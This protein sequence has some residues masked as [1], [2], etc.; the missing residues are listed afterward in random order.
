MTTTYAHFIASDRGNIISSENIV[1]NSTFLSTEVDNS[2]FKDTHCEFVCDVI[3]S[4]TPTLSPFMTFSIIYDLGTGYETPD[5]VPVLFSIPIDSVAKRIVIKNIFILP[6]KFKLAAINTSNQACTV[7]VRVF[8]R[9][10]A[11]ESVE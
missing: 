9:R 1:S 11:L 8:T 6:Y 3:A 2:I 5:A 7:T 4:V 10:M